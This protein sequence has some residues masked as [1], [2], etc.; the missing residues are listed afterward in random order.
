MQG[1]SACGEQIISKDPI[2][3]PL[4]YKSQCLCSRVCHSDFFCCPSISQSIESDHGIYL[5][6]FVI[7]RYSAGSD[8]V[9]YISSNE[10]FHAFWAK[11]A[12][13]CYEDV[14]LCKCGT[15][16]YS[17]ADRSCRDLYIRPLAFFASFYFLVAPFVW[18]ILMHFQVAPYWLAPKSWMVLLSLPLL[19][20][21]VN[22][23]LGL[24]KLAYLYEFRADRQFF[25]L[26]N[27]NPKSYLVTTVLVEDEEGLNLEML[28]L[29]LSW[30]YGCL[31]IWVCCRFLVP[32]FGLSSCP[33]E[34]EYCRH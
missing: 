10:K 17:N 34:S 8:F 6:V 9:P 12:L 3:Y 24:E 5:L 7:R 28:K 1:G 15:S 11:V 14:A 21:L 4:G 2:C 29:Y 25:S 23:D 33:R 16:G 22:I 26:F 32:S 20:R 19:D 13:L 18:N 31:P 30:E 27:H